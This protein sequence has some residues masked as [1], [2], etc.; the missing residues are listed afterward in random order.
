MIRLHHT[1]IGLGRL[2]GPPGAAED[3]KFPTRVETELECVQP[4]RGARAAA[5]QPTVDGAGHGLSEHPGGRGVAVAV[6]SGSQ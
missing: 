5:R 6:L 4:A 2:D 3:V 1:D